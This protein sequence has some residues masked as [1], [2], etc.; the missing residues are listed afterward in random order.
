MANKEWGTKIAVVRGYN[1]YGPGQKS[2]PVKKIVPTM[3]LS[4]L[5]DEPITV[6]GSGDQVADMIYVEDLADILV[7]ALLE[8]HGVYDSIFEAG[9]G[10]P[11][12]VNDVATAVIKAVEDYRGREIGST[13][14][15]VGMRAGEP[16]N[17][18]VL[19]DPN[20]LKPLG[21]D[22][23][24]LTALMIGMRRTVPDYDV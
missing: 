14:S 4:A 19:G 13:V 2:A 6:Y 3:V 1:A 5:R 15:H 10:V 23:A 12:T 17:A 11:T 18:V 16:E 20:T 9:T 8:P 24:Y 22:P 21:V 7:R